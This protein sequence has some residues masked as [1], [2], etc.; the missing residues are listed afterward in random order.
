MRYL[1]MSA[2]LAMTPVGVPAYAQAK[3]GGAMAT[4][5]AGTCGTLMRQY[6]GAS[7]DLAANF[8]SSVGDNSAPRATLRQMEDANSLATAKIAL[9]L[10]R[11]N[12]CP[13]PKSAPSMAPYISQALTC[14]TERMKAS[15]AE[16]PAS[17]DRANWKTESSAK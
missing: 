10:I 14:S 2:A 7:M 1:A 5:P 15:G 3:S 17:C 8:A 11:D 16:S 13:T 12:R 6:D 9:D 4:A